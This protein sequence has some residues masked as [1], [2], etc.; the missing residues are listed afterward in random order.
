MPPSCDPVASDTIRHATTVAVAGSG[1]MIVGPSGSGKSTLALMLMA[2]GAQL[3]ADDRTRLWVGSDGACVWADAPALLPPK[4]E[5]RRVGLL[6]A[7]LCGPVPLV[8]VAD[9]GV[10]EDARLPA[11]RHVEILGQNVALFRAAE[12][13]HF[14]YA[15]LQYLRVVSAVEATHDA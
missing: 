2:H 3:V 1:L 15:I 13:A 4:I 11:P 10:A 6:S 5:A 7:R 12:N 14:A 9:L 8:A